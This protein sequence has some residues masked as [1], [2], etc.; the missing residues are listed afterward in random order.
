MDIQKKIDI[1][2]PGIAF[3]M[4]LVENNPFMQWNRIEMDE[5]DEE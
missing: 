1:S 5:L 2:K 4:R 3:S